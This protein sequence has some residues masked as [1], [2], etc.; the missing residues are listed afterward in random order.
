MMIF[1]IVTADATQFEGLTTKGGAELSDLIRGLTDVQ[2]C[3]VG[4]EE[5]VKSFKNRRDEY[6]YDL[7]PAK[8]AEMNVDKVVVDES[9]VS[10]RPFVSGTMP[11]DPIAKEN[12]LTHLREIGASDFIKNE[13]TVSFGIT[14]DNSAKSLQA[15]L[16]EHGYDTTAKVWVEPMT[17][18]K[19]IRERVEN[20]LDIDLEMF[21][22]H[23]G[24]IAH[25]KKG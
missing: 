14:Q 17:L 1:G 8:M 24:T 15:E 18:K 7:I 6:L 25:I 10:V 12:A 9:E 5:T 20:N 2:R 16:D 21:N 23:V 4:A 3:L 22:A 11:K 19:L 13:V